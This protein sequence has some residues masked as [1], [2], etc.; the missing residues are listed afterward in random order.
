[1]MNKIRELISWDADHTILLVRFIVAV[2]VVVGAIWYYRAHPYNGGSE[3]LSRL[4]IIAAN[5]EPHSATVWEIIAAL[6]MGSLYFVLNVAALLLPF[7]GLGLFLL[8]LFVVMDWSDSHG[9]KN[10]RIERNGEDTRNE[11]AD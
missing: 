1:M 11:N 2:T 3:I 8:T 6:V 5:L 4:N 9:S 10:S 7:L